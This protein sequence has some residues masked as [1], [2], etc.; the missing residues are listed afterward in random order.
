MKLFPILIFPLGYFVLKNCLYL[1][2]LSSKQ[3][4]SV[5]QPTTS[6]IHDILLFKTKFTSLLTWDLCSFHSLS[7][8]QNHFP[9]PLR[10]KFPPFIVT[11]SLKSF[12]CPP[13]RDVSYLT[14]SSPD[15]S[16]SL[17]LV[18][19]FL[20]FSILMHKSPFS[21]LLEIYSTFFLSF[22]RPNPFPFLPPQ[23]L[24]NLISCLLET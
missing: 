6:S 21:F 22:S 9:F 4:R 3:P 16:P 15:Q 8:Y 11:Q 5:T 1:Y 2:V 14:A 20:F 10:L 17:S 13:S 24:M 7:R 23:V 18:M 12:S 19:Y